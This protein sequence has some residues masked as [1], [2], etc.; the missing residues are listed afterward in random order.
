[1]ARHKSALRRRLNGRW[2]RWKALRSLF[3]VAP[4]LARALS[5]PMTSAAALESAVDI[6]ASEVT[7]MS[8]NFTPAQMTGVVL[9]ALANDKI[10]AH[11]ALRGATI[12]R[13]ETAILADCAVLGHVGALIRRCDGALVYQR[14]ASAPKWNLAKPKRLR[15]R[16]MGDGLVISLPATGQYYHFFE[17][18]LPLIDYLDR[19][20]VSGTP[21][22]VLT[23]AHAP[24]F[25]QSVFSAV[26]TAFPDVRFTPLQRHERAEV[27]RY[28]WLHEALENAEWMPVTAA[29]AARL[30][31]IMRAAY[32]QPE[33]RGGEL[34]VFSRGDAKL[35][36]LLNEA[37]LQ[38]IAARHGF[39]PF[40]AVT[41]NHP[42]QVRRFGDA[43]VIVAVHGAGLAN[44]LFAR[45]GA[46]VIELFPEDF[47]KS[48][49]LWLCNRLGLRHIAVT[50]SRGS[51]DQD[52]QVEPSLFAASIEE[53]MSALVRP[54][55][56]AA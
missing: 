39:R 21:L 14:R 31:A 20:H 5:F 48:T 43:D 10:K 1:L 51:Y 4:S 34:M 15:S 53:A 47:V 28:L 19:N 27:R 11:R 42:E 41:G 29:R 52:F 46:T 9:P 17:T 56:A 37:E 12:I 36:R 22:T 49:Y 26:E 16:D 30:G 40:E 23:P 18:L 13:R 54:A 6:L 24:A 2:L 35:R 25:Q 38:A 33:P 50:G 44:L 3:R 8:G 32:G 45:P 7:V 55:S